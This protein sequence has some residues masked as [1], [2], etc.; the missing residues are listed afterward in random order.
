VRG[1]A[2]RATVFVLVLLAMAL[3]AVQ[4][5]QWVF[6]WRAQRMV[7]EFRSL[8]ERQG[9][10]ADLQR[11][12]TEWGAWGHYDGPCDAREC[13]YVVTLLGVDLRAGA[14]TVPLLSWDLQDRFGIQAAGVL[15]CRYLGGHMA[16][17]WFDIRVRGGLVESASLTIATIVPKGYGPGAEGKP[18]EPVGYS[19]DVY[20]VLGVMRL[21]A[22][23]EVK[24]H[25][26]SSAEWPIHATHPLYRA[27]PPD[28]C[29]SCMGLWTEFS[30]L[31]DKRD[32]A[33]MTDYNF[34]CITRWKPCTTQK[35]AMP[36]AWAEYSADRQIR[37]DTDKAM[38]TCAVPIA[39]LARE[40]DF[41]LLV[42]VMHEEA[43]P[44][45]LWRVKLLSVLKGETILRDGQEMPMQ[46]AEGTR[47]HVAGTVPV[48]SEWIVLPWDGGA[49]SIPGALEP[50]QC[51]VIPATEGNL[52]EVGA[53][54]GS[55]PNRG[56]GRFEP[57]P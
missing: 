52:R 26:E 51:G 20:S 50:H 28:G 35:D 53:G 55:A 23:S 31:T 17:A 25:R 38:E 30:L 49:D 18:G 57:Q 9:T 24:A 27:H 43:L 10:W 45:P 4:A 56:H 1:W 16:L 34:D 37:D 36:A 19:G 6:R 48:G 3:V 22:A 32:V 11:I 12:Q 39:K 7:A 46:V 44:K 33:R 14:A 8:A 2:G 47:N 40:A 54:D 42:K 5:G 15:L 13:E 29:T 21:K 41:I